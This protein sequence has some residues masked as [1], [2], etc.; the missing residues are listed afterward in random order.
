M[1]FREAMRDS[2]WNRRSHRARAEAWLAL[3]AVL[4]FLAAGLPGCAGA[5]HRTTTAVEGLA[6]PPGDPR[7]RLERILEPRGSGGGAGGFLRR[8]AGKADRDALERP[9]A[10][11]WDGED[12]LI[13]DPGSSQVVRLGPG[14]RITAASRGELASPIGVAVCPAGIVVSDSRGGGVARFDS[15]L[16]FEGW[17]AEGLER[18]TGV[19]CDGDRVLVVET[20]R[21]R[22]VAFEPT[23]PQSGGAWR[24]ASCFGQRGGG[25][26]ELNYPAAVASGAGSVWVGDTLNFR[27]QRFT[28]ADG[29]FQGSFGHLGDAPG[30]MPRIKGLA[31]DRARQLWISDA[32]LDQVSLYT[33]DGTFLIA[34]GGRGG[35]PGSFSFPAGIAAHPDGRVAVV[36]SLN[37]RIQ[38][39]RLVEREASQSP[40][41]VS[42]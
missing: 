17:I 6:W 3:A 16:H 21:H 41:E 42:R 20:G 14:G 7:V 33:A 37:R 19:A 40:P 35:A 15:R 22:V 8:L 11:A 25:A 1:L 27:L 4:G 36:D 26:G 38:I 12:L 2:A 39:F 32:H 34:L 24:A 13:T 18:P 30:E 23:G 10:A 28:A 31:V 29:R 5:G 9:Y